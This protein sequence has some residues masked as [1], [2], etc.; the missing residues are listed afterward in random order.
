VT[1]FPLETEFQVA[2]VVPAG[3][4]WSNV[5]DLGLFAITQLNRG[6]APDGR[7][8]V[9]EENLTETWRPQA[10]IGSGF[11][12][13]LGWV[14]SDY[15]EQPL[16]VHDGGTLGY[17]AEIAFL[18]E[19][20]VGVTIVVNQAGAMTFSEAVRG[21]VFE[22][23]FDQP[24]EG[25]AGIEFAVE[26]QRQA[27][28]ELAE[29]LIPLDESRVMPY[30]GAWEHPALGEVT[31]ELVGGR[32]ILDAGEFVSEIVVARDDETGEMVYL[33]ATPPLGGLRISLRDETGPRSLVVHAP[34]STDLY[35]FSPLLAASASPVATPL[36]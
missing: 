11:S 28:A 21:R 31:L 14:I 29:A 19:A 22:M 2:P 4:V 18:P 6:V 30:L 35:V 34:A 20:G 16:L 15:K 7:T 32:L 26:Q 9:P 3:G 8:V 23:A 1:E 13:G 5:E 36:G 17:S 27:F 33:T 25:G 10:Q 12:Y 24:A